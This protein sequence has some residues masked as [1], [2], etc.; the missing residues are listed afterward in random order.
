MSAF[1]ITKII[2]REIIDCR[3]WPTVQ[4]D[5][6]VDGQLRGRADVPAGRSTGSHEAHVLLDGDRGRYRGLGVLKAVENVTNVI[7]PELVG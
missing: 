2:A 5:V 3:G 1:A 4:A 6:W 7:G